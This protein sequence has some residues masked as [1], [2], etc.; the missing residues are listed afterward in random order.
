MKAFLLAR[1]AEKSTIVTIVTLIAGV[2]GVNISPENKDLIVGAVIAVVS[3][4]A[5]FWGEDKK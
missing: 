2:A 5:A 3:A 1:L 4:V